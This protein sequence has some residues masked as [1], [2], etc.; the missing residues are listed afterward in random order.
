MIHHDPDCVQ[1]TRICHVNI[2]GGWECDDGFTREECLAAC[3]CTV[4]ADDARDS[5]ASR[6][7]AP[8]LSCMSQPALE[9]TLEAVSPRMLVLLCRDVADARVRI[10]IENTIQRIEQVEDDE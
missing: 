3:T 7:L 6:R 1:R 9:A 2:N 4:S 10:E 5:D 8:H